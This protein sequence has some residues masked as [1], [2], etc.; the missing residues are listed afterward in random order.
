MQGA[1]FCQRIHARWS[2]FFSTLLGQ[3]SG[4]W[5]RSRRSGIG[6]VRPGGSQRRPESAAKLGIIT[7]AS[8]GEASQGPSTRSKVM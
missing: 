1:E 3:G 7:S 5:Q 4:G 6:D 2:S 8:A